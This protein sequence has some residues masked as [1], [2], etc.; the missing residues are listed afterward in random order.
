MSSS[1]LSGNSAFE[2]GGIFSYSGPVTV[3]NSTLSGN[4][5]VFGGG[6]RILNGVPLS[7]SSRTLSGNSPIHSGNGGGIYNY[8]TLT[9]STS[10]L[11]GNLAQGSSSS[12]GYGGG[13]YNSGGAVTLSNNTLSGNS[14]TGYPGG[15]GIYN[16]E[17]STVTLT[18][19]IVANS[20]K[21]SNCSGTIAEGVGYNLDSGTSCGFSLNT[22]LN[23]TDPKLDLLG[24]NGGPTQTMALLQ[25]SP[26][27]DW[28]AA[29]SC[30]ATDQRGYTRPDNGE[31]TC[32][33]GA[34]ESSY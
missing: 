21:G 25:G 15:G 9:V 24:D 13:I 30:T 17:S 32:D 31:S 1:T 7:V 19:T 8:G 27:I 10:T 33:I 11:S 12:D 28:V 34:Y 22:D 26:A 14:A 3:T 5:A 23:N 6:D 18:S 20:P 2:G 4:S 29:T 16:Y